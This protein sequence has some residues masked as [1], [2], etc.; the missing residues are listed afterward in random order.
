M[1]S[2]LAIVVLSLLVGFGIGS[3]TTGTA[4]AEE[5]VTPEP[6]PQGDL[7]KVC[8]DKKTGVI[9]ASGKC[10]TTEK[11]YSLGGPGPQGPQGEKGDTGAIGPQGIQGVKGDMGLQGLKGIQGDRGLQGP[12]G[13]QGFT[14]PT[15][16]VTGLR[17]E[18]ID[19]LSG[20]AF[21]CPG[22]GTSKTVVTDVRLSTF[23][24]STSLYPTTTRLYGCSA[25]VYVR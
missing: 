20:S 19:F 12:Q 13:V 17:T 16:A 7:L 6:V 9:R 24:N 22:F 18:N 5:V 4:T 23:L 10:K 8:I 14:G 15:G 21:G 25:T 3:V 2:K 1:K 11:S